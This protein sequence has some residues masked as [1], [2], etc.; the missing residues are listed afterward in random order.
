MPGHHVVKQGLLSNS[1]HCTMSTAQLYSGMITSA[2]HRDQQ[3]TSRLTAHLAAAALSKHCSRCPS[4]WVDWLDGGGTT[5]PALELDLHTDI[6]QQHHEQ[7][8][9]SQ[10]VQQAVQEAKW[11]ATQSAH[12]PCALPQPLRK[13]DQCTASGASKWDKQAAPNH[14][15]VDTAARTPSI[16][17]PESAWSS[18]CMPYMQAN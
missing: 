13:R 12:K 11:A 17:A 7:A 15:R 14:G 18:A 3:F 5:A 10:A 2:V 6:H 4:M 8:M 9:A 16:H 1:L